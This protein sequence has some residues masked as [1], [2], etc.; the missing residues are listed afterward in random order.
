MTNESPRAASAGDEAGAPGRSLTASW[1]GQKFPIEAG[2]AW[3]VGDLKRK[4]HELTRVEPKRQK[5]VGLVRGKPPTDESPLAGLALL[6]PDGAFMLLGTVEEAIQREQELLEAMDDIVNDLDDVVYTVRDSK[7]WMS[8]KEHR[9]QLT[10]VTAATKIHLINPPLRENTR[11]LVLDLDYTVFD[12]K[13]QASHIGEL[14]RPGLHAFLSAIY[15]FYEIAIWSQTS[16]RWLE[17]KITEMGM[18]THPAYKIAFV[19]D[20]TSMFSITSN[21]GKH[22]V[23]ALDIIWS[24]LPV[25]SAKN[26]IHL[27]DLS[28][29]FAMNPASGLKVVPFKNGPSPASRADRELFKLAKYLLRIS[30]SSV[31]DFTKLNH[32]NWTDYDGPSFPEDMEDRLEE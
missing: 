27:D 5:L 10:K 15:P 30:H 11:L 8:S 22:Q 14:M 21:R 9:D 12:C 20:K 24:H 28:R 2:A 6:K 1:S 31:T 16:W 29:N 25:F 23:K 3:T 18:L 4:L 19:L 13:S 26:T 32:K 17:A 7:E